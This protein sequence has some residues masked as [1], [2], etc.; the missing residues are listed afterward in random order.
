MPSFQFDENFN[1]KKVIERCNDEGHCIAHRFPQSMAGRG[2]KDPEVLKTLMVGE[3]PI[4]TF[5]REIVEEHGEHIPDDNPGLIIV[6]LRG[7]VKTMTA[8]IGADILHRFKYNYP[9]WRHED[10]RCLKIDITETKVQV[11]TIKNYRVAECVDYADNDFISK[12]SKLLDQK[13]KE[14]S[15]ETHQLPPPHLV[16]A[17]R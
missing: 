3:S 10:I 5:D 6:R 13:R 7:A 4:I 14:N 8:K 11:S 2:C 17:E 12:F 15:S 16:T 9:N 1:A